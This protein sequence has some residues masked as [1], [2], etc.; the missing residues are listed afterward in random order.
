MRTR[1]NLGGMRADC[2]RLA[3]MGAAALLVCASGTSAFAAPRTAAMVV[4]M[5][6][7]RILS[8]SHPDR[9]V[10]PASLTKLMTLYL[11]FEALENAT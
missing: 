11:V 7:G 5:H 9:R 2:A 3:W 1:I 6:T 4:D 8:Q 10:Y